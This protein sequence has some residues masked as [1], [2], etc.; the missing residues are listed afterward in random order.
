M[1]EQRPAGAC[2][3]IS[4]IAVIFILIQAG[5]LVLYCEYRNIDTR[6]IDWTCVFQRLFFIYADERCLPSYEVDTLGMVVLFLLMLL[7]PIILF[8]IPKL[9]SKADREAKNK[10]VL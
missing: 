9:E 7:V 8:G 5:S 4:R 2:E 6:S 1:R 10:K 3:R